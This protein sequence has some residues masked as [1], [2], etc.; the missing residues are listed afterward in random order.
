MGYLLIAELKG[1]VMYSKVGRFRE[2][3]HDRVK[4][5]DRSS[6]A[7][8]F[9]TYVNRCLVDADRETMHGVMVLAETGFVE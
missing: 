2:L 5:R 7:M 8:V 6:G 1:E 4:R 9:Q 3:D